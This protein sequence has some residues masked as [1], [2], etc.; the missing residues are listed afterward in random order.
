MSDYLQALNSWGQPQGLWGSQGVGVGTDLSMPSF[1]PD[2][3][4][5]PAAG[6]DVG[7]LQSM[8]G[9]TDPDGTQNAGWGMPA[10][11]TLSGLAGLWM[12]KQQLDLAKKSLN[13][14]K[15]QFNLN[16][17]NQVASYNTQLEDRQRARVASNSQA[18]ESV[19]SYLKRNQ[20]PGAG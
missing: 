3:A 10:L 13:E 17:N 15:R 11:N 20:L 16:Y 5:G 8:L 12:G 19:G 6:T 4:G 2:A 18:Y 7:F 14:N 1:M 9:W